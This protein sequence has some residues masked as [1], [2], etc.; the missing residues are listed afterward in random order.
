M[1]ALILG[2]QQLNK[3]LAQL[4]PNVNRGRTQVKIVV[5]HGAY[6]LNGPGVGEEVESWLNHMDD[7]FEVMRCMVDQRVST[8]TFFMVKRAKNW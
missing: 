2:L 5:S 7:V 8:S 4:I 6:S 3:A 1:N